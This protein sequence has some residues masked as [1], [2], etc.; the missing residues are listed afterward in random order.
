[1]ATFKISGRVHR[2]TPHSL[3][4]LNIG[5]HHAM[6]DKA[7]LI[8]NPRRNAAYYNSGADMVSC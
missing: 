1:M 5:D 4:N 8:E 2:L 7:K 3:P 6:S